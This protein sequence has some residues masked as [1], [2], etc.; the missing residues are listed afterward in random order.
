MMSVFFP[1]EKVEFDSLVSNQ[2][3][4]LLKIFESEK[5]LRVY[6]R[7]YRVAIFKRSEPDS[8]VLAQNRIVAY[9]S[10]EEFRTLV[11]YD[12]ERR[13]SPTDSVY[14]AFDD[15]SDSKCLRV[16]STKEIFLTK[17]FDLS[18]ISFEKPLELLVRFNINLKD[19]LRKPLLYAVDITKDGKLIFQKE[20]SITPKDYTLKSWSNIEFR[21]S[22]PSKISFNG[23]LKTSILNQNKGSYLLDDYQIGYC[24]KR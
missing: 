19:T 2:H 21:V 18:T 11:S 13:V 16:D 5:S 24:L 3:F 1:I 9:G 7:D 15:K 10:K 14:L 12:F 17:E 6:G 4:E 20:I 23:I 22:F 8:S